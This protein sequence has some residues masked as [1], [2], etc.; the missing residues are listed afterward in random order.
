VLTAGLSFFVIIYQE[1]ESTPS[2]QQKCSVKYSTGR[3][4]GANITPLR[5]G[6]GIKKKLT[7]NSRQPPEYRQTDVD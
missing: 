1:S 6:K 7:D 2:R 4:F 3:F 5:E